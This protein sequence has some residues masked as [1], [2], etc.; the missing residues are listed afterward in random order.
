MGK[1]SNTYPYPFSAVGQVVLD[2]SN[3]VNNWALFPDVGNCGDHKCDTAFVQND[4]TA[5]VYF[6]FTKD[7]GEVVGGGTTGSNDTNGQ[8]ILGGM[9]FIVPLP[10]TA[11]YLNAICDSGTSVLRVSVGRGQ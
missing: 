8:P 3:S 2:I 11:T 6:T 7:P 9:G 5:T 1:F 4:G 10:P